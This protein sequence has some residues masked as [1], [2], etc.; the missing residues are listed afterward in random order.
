MAYNSVATPRFYVDELQYVKSIGLDVEQLYLNNGYPYP[1]EGD[2]DSRTILTD[3][4]LFTFTPEI[5]KNVLHLKIL[6]E[7]APDWVFTN[8]MYWYIPNITEGHLVEDENIGRYVAML[9]H[10]LGDREL[11]LFH[12][13]IE[14]DYVWEGW[15]TDEKSEILNMDD[16]D[17]KVSLNGS[18]IFKLQDNPSTESKFRIMGVRIEDFPSFISGQRANEMNLGTLS[19]GIY[20]DMTVNPDLNLTMEMEFKGYNSFETLNGST[21]T[22]TINPGSTWWYDVSGNRKDPWYVGESSGISKANRRRVW[23]LGFSYIS[24]KDLLS[25]NPTSSD[26][27][28]SKIGVEPSDLDLSFSN[29][30]VTNGTFTGNANGWT[31]DSGWA[32]D[33]NNVT[34]S[35][36]NG[37]LKQDVGAVGFNLYS[38]TFKIANYISGDLHIDIG[39][40][41]PAIFT[42]EHLSTGAVFEH[43]FL[44]IN[45]NDVRFY[46]GAFRGSLDNIE[47]RTANAEIFKYNIDTDSSFESMVLNRISNG[48]KFIFQPDNNENNP[49]D[50]AICTLDQ[51]STSIKR[52][53]PNAYNIKMKIKEVW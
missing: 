50:F 51:D 20:Y 11:K 26:Y 25:S 24:D 35:S 52:V 5:Q 23:S 28:V 33:D 47:V 6:L 37:S 36:L 12:K 10:D 40:S 16:S 45:T 48:E 7:G 34:C 17:G 49:S 22:R 8:Q 15:D 39:G 32:Y 44:S 30:L 2:G 14:P 41:S 31:L 13:W 38:I 4:D 21:L 42:S 18:T 9:N 27:M 46:G 3:P 1:L 19:Y 29:N 43:Y 53:A